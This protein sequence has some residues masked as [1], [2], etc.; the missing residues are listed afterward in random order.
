MGTARRGTA[1]W[2]KAMRRAYAQALRYAKYLPEGPPPFLLTCDIGNV[3][4]LWTG[5]SGAY[6]WEAD[7][8][9]EEILEKL[10]A[11]NKQRAAEEKQG[12]VRW[13]RPDFQDPEGTARPAQGELAGVEEVQVAVPVAKRSWP[14]GVPQQLRAI[15]DLVASRAGTWGED[16]VASAFK[17][18]PRPKVAAHLSTLEELGVLIAHEEGGARRYAA[19][20]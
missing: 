10:V 7:L 3:F 12:L 13:L 4:E 15:R 8:S 20:G 1:S 18:A 6:G 16:E 19:L 2:D 11:L 5:F 17:S 9:D 14:K